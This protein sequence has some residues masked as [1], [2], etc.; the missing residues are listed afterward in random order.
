MALRRTAAGPKGGA[1]E[2]GP[3]QP[4][5]EAAVLDRVRR[6]KRDWLDA[7]TPIQLLA[8]CFVMAILVGTILLLLPFSVAAGQKPVSLIDALFTATS[9]V[10]VTG[11][12][13]VDT[14]AH[15]SPFG[16][17]VIL[18]LIQFGGL[19]IMTAS[20]FLFLALGQRSS[21]RNL[22]L[23]RNEYTVTGFASAKA[24]IITVAGFT[25]VMESVG[26][27]VL[28]NRF[29]A[30]MPVGPAIWHG[31]FHSVSAF[32]NAGFSLF[33][34]SFSG[35]RQDPTITL[36]VPL[37][38]IIGGLGFP[39]LIDLFHKVR[40]RLRGTRMALSLHAK[41][42]F[43]ASAALLALGTLAFF[44]F[45]GPRAQLRDAPM[46]EKIGAAWFQSATTR[47]AGFNTIEFAEASEPALLT[48]IVLMIIGGSPGS[49]AGGIKIT[50]FVVILLVVI[51]RLRGHE[52]VEIGKRTL[53]A[54]VITKALVVALLGVALIV[55]AT[56]LLLITDG[57]TAE[58]GPKHGSFV[59][60]LFEV[61][62][63]FGTV[64]LS[65]INAGT[66][67]W[68]G[69]LIIICVMYLGRLGP[70]ALAQMVL[71][72]DKPLKYRYPEEHLLVG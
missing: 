65:M 21:L 14:G 9:A 60:L 4:G 29:A 71:A 70:L 50:T 12:I 24:L 37:L 11:L 16:Q 67:T 46:A 5:L 7:L 57:A 43:A 26:A 28:A 31:I 18:A 44:A 25:F 49:T 45:E 69:K 1:P 36:A 41:I 53:P 66:L 63:A 30:E 39:A 27:V 8:L 55:V 51:A 22:I 58:T 62:S 2:L 6:V 20:T 52:R 13:V 68:M 59:S 23:L 19:G 15:F 47:T 64:G 33:S 35:Y 10:C 56:L 32:C 61:V 34:E 38:I 40:A 72:A 54:A 17:G 42:V 3:H 48:T